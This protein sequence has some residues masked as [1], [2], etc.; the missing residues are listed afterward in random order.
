M[1]TGTA[2]V[3]VGAGA[4]SAVAAGAGTYGMYRHKKKQKQNKERHR[5]MILKMESQWEPLCNGDYVDSSLY[6]RVSS[7]IF[8]EESI[9]L[10]S[11]TSF[12]MG[13]TEENKLSGNFSASPS[14]SILFTS[15][16]ETLFKCL[17]LHLIP[18]VDM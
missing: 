8:D 10:P 5:Q 11:V 12:G 3:L 17:F 7:D 4:A 14:V 13:L 18:M 1:L 16:Q 9:T 2:V 6:P 15:T